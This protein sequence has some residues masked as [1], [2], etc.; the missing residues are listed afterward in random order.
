[1]HM[2]NRTEWNSL[3][4]EKQTA[5]A[6]DIA[7]SLPPQFAFSD[8]RT[9]TL[10]GVTQRVAQFLADGKTTFS[11]IPG[12][13]VS[14]GF[15]SANWQPNTD[16]EESWADTVFEYGTEDSLWEYL[17][18]A[19]TARRQVS[20]SPFLIE[21][22]AS[23]VGWEP[24]SFDDPDVKKLV[25]GLP[26]GY[27]KYTNSI[28]GERRIRVTRHE[29][30]DLTAEIAIQPTHESLVADLRD[31]GFRFPTSDEWEYACGAGA[32]TLFRWGDHVPCDRY[33][34]DI[35][36][37]EAAWRRAWVLS[38]GKLEYPASGFKSDWDYHL[39]PNV[40]GVFIAKDPSKFELVADANMTRGGDGGSTICG[41]AGFF[42]GWLT[43]ATAYFE[44]DRCMIDPERG[45]GV[46]YT[47][48]RRVLPLH[49]A[50]KMV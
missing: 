31:K 32:G 4:Y 9:F 18:N 1:M 15:D 46:G 29:G 26:S 38:C 10:G 36:P 6:R 24:A 40:F 47:I 39:R 48:G 50:L 43:L 12:G 13:D 27:Q 34:T 3:S 16:E 49:D 42:I 17:N 2:P 37:E 35:S 7:A 11:L 20:M 23:E 33:P 30:G 44:D 22:A 41:G 14:L 21:T 8:V 5:I 25:D 28:S 19:T 45:I